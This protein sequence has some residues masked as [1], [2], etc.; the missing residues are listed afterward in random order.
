MRQAAVVLKIIKWLKRQPVGLI[1]L[2]CPVVDAELEEELLDVKRGEELP[3]TVDD[4]FSWRLSQDWQER[5]HNLW[6]GICNAFPFLGVEALVDVWV[7]EVVLAY[8]FDLLVQGLHLG[9]KLFPGS[10]R[11]RCLVNAYI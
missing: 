6:I 5:L 10:C 8:N 9:F 2:W 11:S 3:L 1:W 4:D 7:P